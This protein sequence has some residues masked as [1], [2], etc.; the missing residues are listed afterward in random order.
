MANKAIGIAG[1]VLPRSTPQAKPEAFL[2]SRHVF[3][4]IFA[5]LREP[6]FFRFG[7]GHAAVRVRGYLSILLLK[8]RVSRAQNVPMNRMSTGYAIV[9]PVYPVIL[10]ILFG[11]G[12]SGLG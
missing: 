8:F 3:F 4:A 5:A 1:A 9:H 11:S 6:S 12:L 10:F 2:F 7:P